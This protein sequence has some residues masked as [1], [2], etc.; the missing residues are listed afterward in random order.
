M[1]FYKEKAGYQL[2]NYFYIICYVHNVKS[3]FNVVMMKLM[4][5]GAKNR[6]ASSLVEEPLW[7]SRVKND[8]GVIIDHRLS[9][10]MQRL[11][12]ACKIL[13]CINKGIKQSLPLYKTLVWPHLGY[14]IK[15]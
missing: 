14:A 7:K 4:H 10:G 9:N 1:S 15:F 13:P 6:N 5:L 3:S 11:A 8:L 12:A 2:Q